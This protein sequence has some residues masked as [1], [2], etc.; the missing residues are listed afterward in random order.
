MFCAYRCLWTEKEAGSLEVED[1]YSYSFQKEDL[2]RWIDIRSSTQYSDVVRYKASE[3]EVVRID[4]QLMAKIC[5][6]RV[7][8][9][10]AHEGVK[11]LGL[12][13]DYKK[14]LK[15]GYGIQ[16]RVEHRSS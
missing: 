4:V 6:H 10:D 13:S 3:I 11:D 15:K 12:L 5:K 1:G 14:G 9:T 7:Y 16:P 8:S 2:Q